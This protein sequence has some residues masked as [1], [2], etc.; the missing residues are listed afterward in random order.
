M[1]NGIYN[2]TIPNSNYNRSYKK[3]SLLTTKEQVDRSHA[4]GGGPQLGP[5]RG[6]LYRQHEFRRPW[7]STLPDGEHEQVSVYNPE[8]SKEIATIPLGRKT[9]DGKQFNLK[10]KVGNISE[11]SESS[12]CSYCT[13]DL[14]P[15]GVASGTVMRTHSVPDN[16]LSHA[17][18]LGEIPMSCV[19]M[20]KPYSD[21]F[22]ALIH[23]AV[24]MWQGGKHHEIRWLSTTIG[25]VIEECLF[26]SLP[27]VAI[28]NVIGNWPAQTAHSVLMEVLIDFAE[29]EYPNSQTL[30]EI[31]IYFDK[32]E[33]AKQFADLAVS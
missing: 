8:P 19:G 26:N 20:T 28:H 2:P 16:L 6:H 5:V 10:V 15:V 25:N 3:T 24:P 33:D 21:S 7:K 23:T 12:V 22:S 32:E 31:G 9:E 17:K 30:T 4:F 11:A 18:T 27:S 29:C 13:G 1:G 14:S